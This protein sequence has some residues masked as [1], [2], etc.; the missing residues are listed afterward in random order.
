MSKL[1][2]PTRSHLHL[3]KR[4]TLWGSGVIVVLFLPRPI[5]PDAGLWLTYICSMTL[6]ILSIWGLTLASAAYRKE[7]KAVA[8]ILGATNT[9][10]LLASLMATTMN[11]LQ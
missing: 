4:I 5:L 1:N 7:C 10:L 9:L 6:A 2:T 8:F 3:R 11:I